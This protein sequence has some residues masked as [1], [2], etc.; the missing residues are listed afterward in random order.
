MVTS[1]SLSQSVDSYKRQILELYQD[2]E[3]TKIYSGNEIELEE[4]TEIIIETISLDETMNLGITSDINKYL[5]I[6][7]KNKL[8]KTIYVESN[9][10]MYRRLDGVSKKIYL[11][12]IKK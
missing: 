7:D 2:Y 9:Q 1:I 6:Q 5:K 8:V 3:F 11:R 4:L 10:L 12:T